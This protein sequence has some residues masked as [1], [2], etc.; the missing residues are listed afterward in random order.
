[1]T[2]A[3]IFASGAASA[4]AVGPA[5]G[6]KAVAAT[7]GGAGAETLATPGFTL[8]QRRRAGVRRASVRRGG[9]RVRRVGVRRG[10]RTGPRFRRVGSRRWYGPRYRRRGFIPGALA[11]G[12][13]GGALGGWG[14]GSRGSGW[15]IGAPLLGFG[16]GT[17][18]GAGLAGAGSAAGGSGFVGYSGSRPVI[19]R[20]S[21]AAV[22]FCARNFP[23]FNPS[24]GTYTSGGQSVRCPYL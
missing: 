17:A 2:C 5:L 18:I 12:L 19:V 24:T 11:L 22:A 7:V 8:V 4:A 10:F 15:G 20:G 21:P 13:A 23:S 14:W 1:M 16:I 9:P 3:A 6:S